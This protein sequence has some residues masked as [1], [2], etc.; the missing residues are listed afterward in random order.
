[1]RVLF[2]VELGLPPPPPHHNLLC[3]PFAQCSVSGELVRCLAP[4]VG[5]KTGKDK[6]GEKEET[7]VS[8]MEN[9]FSAAA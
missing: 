4:E 9:G 3:H 6:T 8:K 1:M 2:D 7:L 5:A